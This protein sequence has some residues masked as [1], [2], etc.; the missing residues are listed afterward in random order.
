MH[1]RIVTISIGIVVALGIGAGSNFSMAQQ[2]S[3]NPGLPLMPD[4]RPDLHGVWHFNTTTPLQ[5]PESARN[6]PHYTEEEHAA[7]AARAAGSPGWDNPPPD[8]SVGSYNQFWWDRGGPV[9]DRRTSL[10]IDPPDGRLPSLTPDAI[11]QVGSVERHVPGALPV[12]YRIGGLG[13]DGPEERGLAARC[14]VGYN[15]GPPLL[16]GGYNNNL[17]VFQSADHVVILTEMVHTARIVP[18]TDRPHLPEAI[19]LWNGDARGHWDGDTLVI[20]TTN[21]SP[22]RASF[23][24]GATVAFG[25]GATLTLVERLT[26]VTPDTL[27]YEYT[28]D[29][30]TTFSHSFTAAIPMRHS[31]DPIFEYACHEGNY[32]MTNMLLVGRAA[33]TEPEEDADR[34]DGR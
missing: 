14:I 34:T 20:E 16:P 24:P 23:E 1:A 19:R 11:R 15:V 8:G 21:F 32:G 12:R 25:T 22:K 31:T 27:V 26:R 2:A 4:G 9:E 30:P 28:V 33:D 29:D 10:I 13:A 5:R 18:I 3:S 6:R 17:Q 7:L